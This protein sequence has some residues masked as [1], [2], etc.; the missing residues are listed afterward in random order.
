MDKAIVDSE[1]HPRCRH[2]TNSTKHNVASNS[3]PLVPLCENKTSSTKPEVHK[4]L[5][6]HRRKTEP[7]MTRTENCAKFSHVVL[8]MRSDRQTHRQTDTDKQTDRHFHRS[9]HTGDEVIS[10]GRIEKH[11]CHC[12][13]DS[14]CQHRT[15][16]PST[17]SSAWHVD[18]VSFVRNNEAG[19]GHCNSV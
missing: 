11:N 8:D 15:I 9:L 19:A 6:C 2:M 14:K 7:Q 18:K 4:I 1:L 17:Y 10:R 16:E 13:S 5:R 3:A 12:I